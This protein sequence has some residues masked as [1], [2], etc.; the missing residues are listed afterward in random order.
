MAEA[1]WAEADARLPQLQ[2]AARKDAEAAL[3]EERAALRYAAAV[4]FR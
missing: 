3:A 1:R 4:G 2:A